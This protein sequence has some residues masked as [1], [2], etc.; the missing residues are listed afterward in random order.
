MRQHHRL[1]TS[2]AAWPYA[3]FSTVSC[4]VQAQ[5]E[6]H[7]AKAESGMTEPWS[8]AV[9]PKGP[10]TPDQALAGMAHDPYAIPGFGGD[11]V[12]RDSKQPGLWQHIWGRL[13][14]G[15]VKVQV[16]GEDWKRLEVLAQRLL[17]SY[18]PKA[19]P[20]TAQ[21]AA[22]DAQLLSVLANIN[23]SLQVCLRLVMDRMRLL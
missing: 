13:G 6:E 7:A 14:R 22:H 21:H 17:D 1:P 15:S 4:L 3:A 10:I 20:L 5:Q 23:A 12:R 16:E 2:S 11:I 8:A 19:A 18:Y 9:I